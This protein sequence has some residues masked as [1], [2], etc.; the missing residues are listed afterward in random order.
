M[1]RLALLLTVFVWTAPLHDTQ[2]T[3]INGKLVMDPF[4]RPA[5]T[6][7]R[8]PL[9]CEVWWDEMQ[10]NPVPVFPQWETECQPRIVQTFVGLTPGQ[11]VTWDDHGL[12]GFGTC[13]IV[14]VDAAGNRSVPSNYCS[15][16]LKP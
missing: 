1:T 7:E 16:R 5:V 10:H 12:L 6:V 8:G 11:Q 15:S 4:G 9:T 3:T 2:V 13:W 14:T